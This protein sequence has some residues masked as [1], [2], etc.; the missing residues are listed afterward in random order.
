MTAAEAPPQDA[1]RDVLAHRPAMLALATLTVGSLGAAAQAT[2]LGYRV[3][4]L[5]RR[6]LD[7]GWLGLAEF[8]PSVLLVA[9]SGPIADRLDRRK[10]VAASFVGEILCAAALAVLA[11]SGAGA[12][13][14]IFAVVALFGAARSLGAPA[15]RALIPDVVP[16]ALLPRVVA[17]Q[18]ATWQGARIVG[19]VIGGALAAWS[20]SAAYIFT[21]AAAGAAALMIGAV[22]VHTETG[23]RA[24]TRADAT[25]TGTQRSGRTGSAVHEAFAGL[26]E[27]RRLPVLLGAISLDLFAVLFGGAVALLP[28][29]ARERLGLGATGLGWLHAAGGI[30]AAAVTLVLAG[31]PI[32]R[33]I[34]GWLYASVAVFGAAT[35]LLGATRTAAVAV[36]AM[37]VLSAADSVSVFI[38]ATLVPLVTPPGVRGRVMAVESVF[39]GAS[40]ELGAFESGVVGNLLGASRTVVVGGAA[41]IAVVAIWAWRFPTLRR[42]DRFPAAPPTD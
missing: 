8:L 20:P 22:R 33:H 36:V 18:S 25:E 4:E 41:T 23:Y 14:A 26:R 3:F 27:V 17:L 11:R 15:A 42:V 2:A 35:V 32:R 37:V 38:R 28:A 16:P 24:A 1:L 7:L 30:G 19:P 5:T 31:R 40:N 13:P 9:V 39:I 21:A 34:G 6:E 29:L 10:G 12:L